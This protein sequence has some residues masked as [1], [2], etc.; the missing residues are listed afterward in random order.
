MQ[1]LLMQLAGLNVRLSVENG[2]LRVNAPEG[3]LT[4]ELKL[5]LREHKQALIE[6]LQKTKAVGTAFSLPEIIPD[7]TRR[8]EPF[9]LNEVQH[10]YWVGRGSI[11]ELG[12]VSTYFYYEL[13]CGALDLPRLNRAFCKVIAHHDMLR[14]IIDSE[15]QQRILESVPP[16]EIRLYDL[17]DM[18]A[19]DA[20]QKMF[21]IR[22]EMSQQ[23]LPADRWPLFDIRA[24]QRTDNSIRLYFG[25]DCMVVDAWSLSIIFSQWNDAYHDLRKIWPPLTLSFRDYLLAE[26]ALKET[27]FHRVAHDYW[28]QRIDQ[29]PPAPVLPVKNKIDASKKHRFT[30]RRHR[31]AMD[32]WQAIKIQA[33]SS[34]MTPSGILAAAFAEVLAY[35]SKSPHFCLNLTLFNRLPL[36]SEVNALVGDFTSLTLL[37]VD[38]RRGRTFRERALRIQQQFLEDLEY[39]QVN[40]VEVIREWSKRKGYQRKALFPVVFT[41]TLVVGSSES[42]DMGVLESFGP[43]GYGISQTPQVW[44]DYQV[45]E[46]KGELFFNWD[47]VEDIFLP[48]VLDAMFSA[49]SLLLDKL[50]TSSEYWEQE[51]VLTL[52]AEQ[53]D[54]R[55]VINNTVTERCDEWLHTLFIKQALATPNAVAITSSVRALSYGEVLALSH[56]LAQQLLEKKA[57]PNQLIAVM[58]EKGWE[59]VVAVMGILM[60][61]AAY[62]PIDPALPLQRRR[63]L[64]QQGEA[65]I[66]ITQTF[67]VEQLALPE[68]MDCIIVRSIDHLA[69]LDQAPAPRQRLE[70]LAYVIF[71]S[72]STGMP[73]GVMIDHRGAMNTIWHINRMFEINK[74][75]KVLAVS[76]LSFDLSVYDIFGLL[77]AGGCVVIPDVAGSKDPEHWQML[78]SAHG[79]TVWNSAPPLMNMLMDYMEGLTQHIKIPL[80]L[81]LLSGDWIQTGLPA[82][83]RTYTH[84]PQIISQGGATEG[85]IWSIYYPIKDVPNNW[86]SIPYGK[87]LPNQTMH[88]LN[89]RLQPCPEAVVGHIYIGGQGVALGYWKDTEKTARQF[90]V[91]PQSGEPLYYTG[92]LGRYFPDKDLRVGNIEFLG[93]EDAQV[94]LHG[95][96]VELGEISANIQMHPDIDDAIVQL[97][98]QEN[99]E[100]LIAYVV[101]H[102]H[103]NNALYENESLDRKT[104]S[105][106][107][108]LLNETAH[109]QARQFYQAYQDELKTFEVFWEKTEAVSKIAML[110]TLQQLDIL[111]GPLLKSQL[112]TK[113][114]NAGVKSQH[115]ALVRQWLKQ[116]SDDG[117]VR[118]EGDTILHAFTK[119]STA[120]EQTLQ[121]LALLAKGNDSLETFY[122]YLQICLRQQSELLQGRLKPLELLFPEGSWR[123]AE[124][125]YQTNP[126]VRMHNSV[127]A[128]ALRSAVESWD[129][130]KKI[131]IIEVGAG[132]GGTT[133]SLLPQL[134]AD[135]T[136]YHYT[137]LS[138][139]FLSGAKSKFHDYPFIHYGTY[140]IDDDPSNQGYEPHSFDV[141]VAV[142]VLH[143][144]K[145]I[146]D[147]LNK[148]KALLAPGGLFLILEGTE[149]TAWQMVTVAY[150]EGFGHYEDERLTSNLPL[151][152]A[153]SWQGVLKQAGFEN[154]ALFPDEVQ[155]SLPI[156]RAMPQHVIVA[157]GPL[158]VS[159][160]ESSGLID[161]LQQ[162]LPDYMVPQQYVALSAMPLSSNG[163]VDIK[164]L[165][166]L[167]QHKASKTRILVAPRNDIEATVLSIWKDVLGVDQLSIHD[168]FFEVGGDSLLITRVMGMI[169]TSTP[170]TV[171]MADL[172]AN[173]TIQS[174][175]DYFAQEIGEHVQYQNSIAGYSQTDTQNNDIAIIGMAGRFPDAHNIEQYWENLKT[176]LCSIQ[177][178][179]DETLL[180]AGVDRETLVRE[181][182]I[183]AGVRLEDMDLFDA[184][185]FNM[186]PRDA[187]MMDPQQRF[188][189][190]CSV[191]A[192]ESAGYP[193]EQYAGKIGVFVGKDSSRYLIYHLL[194]NR[195]LIETMGM[196]AV[197][198]VNEKDYAATQISYKLNLTGPSLNINTACSTSLVAIHQACKSLLSDECKVALA[199]GVSIDITQ[200]AGY[201]YKEGFIASQDGY[202]RAF[203]EDAKGTVGGS[204]VGLVV[205][206]RL[207]QAQADGDTLH[208]VIKGSAINN[209]GSAKVGYTAPSVNGQA[210]VIV[211]AQ[212]AAGVDADSIQ[213]IEAHGTGTKLG[214]PIEIAALKKAF[215][216]G[217][218]RVLP[219]ALG[220][221]KTNMGHLD[222]A[223]GVA[224]LIKTVESLK[225]QQ[226]LP[227]L[228]FSRPNPE[229]DFDNSPFFVNTELRDWN[230]GEMPR[231][232]GVS[233][234]GVGGTNAHVVLEEAPERDVLP[235]THAYQLLPLSAK[236]P[237]ALIEMAQHLT[238]Y[239]QQHKTLRLEDV[240]YTLQL[241]RNEY[242]YRSYW[243][244]RTAPPVFEVSQAASLSIVKKDESQTCAVAFLFPGQGVQRLN[245][246]RMLYRSSSVYRN[247]FDACAVHLKTQ[248]GHDIRDLVYP[249]WRRD[250]ALPDHATSITEA[251]ATALLNQTAMTQPILFSVAYA[252]AKFWNS[253]SVQPQAMMGHSLGEYVAACLAGVFSLEDGL[254][255]VAERGRLIQ[256]L[257]AGGMLAVSMNATDLKPMLKDSACELAAI[258][259]PQQC[260]VSGASVAIERFAA[261][262]QTRKIS[263][264]RLNATH[265]FHSVMMEP[266]LAAYQEYISQFALHT[267]SLRFISTVSGD[268]ITVTEATSPAY[269]ARHIRETVNFEK[270]VQT[271]LSKKAYVLLELGP[272][273]TLSAMLRHTVTSREQIIPS[274]GFGTV[275]QD[276]H[277]AILNTVGRLWQTGVDIRWL[278]MHENEKRRRVSLPAYAF[279][280]QRYWIE[281]VLWDSDQQ[282]L[283]NGHRAHIRT[284]N[285]S[286]EADMMPQASYYQRPDLKTIYIAPRNEME[287]RLTIV[288]QSFLGEVNI[289]IDDNFFE[290][291]GDSLLATQVIVRVKEI[292]GIELPI[293]KLFEFATIRH[294]SNYLSA[295]EN[296]DAVENLSEKEVDDL[297]QMMDS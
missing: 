153:T 198:N 237:A 136:E 118:D 39:R 18:Q 163:K 154:I 285:H 218:R 102:E 209:D 226:M 119:P 262:L 214:D 20:E 138:D 10:A 80:R 253:L 61:G 283:K 187:E 257:E 47:A 54:R 96:R 182:Y 234:F 74:N 274:F 16:Y 35:W 194:P 216:K 90:I 227:S 245:M 147:T 124:A 223:A 271:L 184:G 193:N 62:L 139:F 78:I 71:T 207:S 267:P 268:W 145:K 277:Q 221:V 158:S 264:R 81:V 8:Y 261:Y 168:N 265:A 33:Q 213:Y 127:L 225:H 278:A 31:L 173:P 211:A 255:M 247:A 292:S 276:E 125:L 49:H 27:D 6:R 46:D 34:G 23:V 240:A 40:G 99:R 59:Q 172:F 135:R 275:H 212:A 5:A 258:N 241:G 238:T 143:D 222:A 177:H 161:Y 242:A 156:V 100:Q 97:S 129:A 69:Y 57:K 192:L 231:R 113:L 270:G 134:P 64:L 93:R 32:Q 79:I 133:T 250:V 94:K 203:S 200:P 233:S 208:A 108:A 196:M 282:I 256:N 72:G 174:L 259:G 98:K 70:D 235:N 101:P 91:H 176:G 266:V 130:H 170:Y 68:D 284:K 73:K 224:G 281:R 206:K 148:L 260:V 103:Q 142:N 239:L 201:L 14:A 228:H 137:D 252:L 149:N 36:H 84:E 220:S 219:C 291:G 190:E 11:A 167:R 251:A 131:R 107:W 195:D 295:A 48:G 186:T 114:A 236:T 105:S 43:M 66:A 21:A 53:Q 63:Q 51:C 83:I 30:R 37:E 249:G 67:L 52:P 244:S 141:L 121:S 210:G 92:D 199:G 9:P 152:N 178:Y 3:V 229:I 87:P 15:G 42:G 165:P 164:A 12:N 111:S 56:H 88:V 2:Q 126:A 185:F 155:H 217:S 183:K 85:S 82:R 254:S 65:R 151:L 1:R 44:L 294:I 293:G 122:D 24:V 19:E 202:C 280:R 26:T 55:D 25:W 4:S 204:G 140:N 272:D 95:H 157:Q 106:I 289:G 123:L 188:L 60:A 197:M 132:T 215:G 45:F 38:N 89:D 287:K 112:E 50:A 181:N 110:E 171:T 41:S 162:R 269:W 58:M 117:I 179:S 120:L 160:F 263:S 288:W 180:E 76:S 109:N 248:M 75:D 205:L 286:M 246:G 77:A 86:E 243:V 189:L 279:Q 297:L 150:L 169:N 13:E 104:A 191:E 232:A 7:T 296:A 175:T 273:H 159:R 17:R 144:A 29:L 230:K 166:V 28:W 146:P 115:Y 128:A 290:L 22:N 116:L